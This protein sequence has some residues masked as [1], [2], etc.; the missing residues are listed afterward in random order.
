MADADDPAGG[1]AGAGWGM[2]IGWPTDVRH[3]AHFTFDRL[4]GF[5]GLPVEFEIDKLLGITNRQQVLDLGIGKYNETCRSI[6]TK[7]VAEWEAVVMRMGRWIDY[8][9]DLQG[10]LVHRLGRPHRRLLSSKLSH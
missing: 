10:E 4:Q 1:A 9:A 8:K 6:V 5:L 2:D 7:H 3:V